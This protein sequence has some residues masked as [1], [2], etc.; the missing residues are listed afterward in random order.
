MYT[1]HKTDT[2]MLDFDDDHIDFNPYTLDH[3]ITSESA[4]KFNFSKYVNLIK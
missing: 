2:L 1:H 4:R 3:S